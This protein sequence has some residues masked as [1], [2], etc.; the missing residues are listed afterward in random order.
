MIRNKSLWFFMVFLFSLCASGFTQAQMSEQDLLNSLPKQYGQ[1]QAEPVV[2]YGTPSNGYSRNY[3]YP[4]SAKITVYLFTAGQQ[5]IAD[6]VNDPTVIEAFQGARSAIGDAVK[7][8]LYRNLRP[9]RDYK[10]TISRAF[11]GKESLSLLAASYSF[12]V[13]KSPD[14]VYS[15][16]YVTGLHNFVFKVRVTQGRIDQPSEAEMQQFLSMVVD[17]FDKVAKN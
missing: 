8:G 10:V 5:R 6:G 11:K 3:V 7:M 9:L 2:Y 15:K 1:Y 4:G 14:T 16:L 17:T 13:Q 12:Q